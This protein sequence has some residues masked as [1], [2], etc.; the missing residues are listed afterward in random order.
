MSRRPTTVT[1][2]YLT[3]NPGATWR[4]HLAD[5]STYEIQFDRAS[6]VI[7][8]R[9]SDVGYEH[10]PPRLAGLDAVDGE[11]LRFTIVGQRERYE[12][13]V[14]A[15]TRVRPFCRFCGERLL[16]G[17]CSR[18]LVDPTHHRSRQ[19]TKWAGKPLSW[20]RRLVNRLE[21]LLHWLD[22]R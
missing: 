16:V 18:N 6:A 20:R 10:H 14:T 15:I 8:R 7:V 5:G 17:V 1:A 3:G 2:L 4:V 21:P 13:V 22:G 12:A 11:P 19:E 9:T